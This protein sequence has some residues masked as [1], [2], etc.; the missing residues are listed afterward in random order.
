[1]RLLQELLIRLKTNLPAINKNPALLHSLFFIVLLF[2]QLNAY[3][4]IDPL[5]RDSLSRSIDSSAKRYRRLEDTIITIQDSTYQVA[6]NKAFVQN[7]GS[8]DQL[9][10]EQKR[11]EKKEQQ[12]GFVRMITGVL[13]FIVLAIGIFRKRKP[14]A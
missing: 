2:V 6:T 12:Q 13:L 4:Q 5:K 10:A 14:D 11:K 3:V 8:N 1:M 9:Y 7:S